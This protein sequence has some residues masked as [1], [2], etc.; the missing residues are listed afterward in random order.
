HLQRII[1]F[2]GL[3]ADFCSAGR[4]TEKPKGV[5][6]LQK[7]C[8]DRYKGL[9]L[10]RKIWQ[11]GLQHFYGIFTYHFVK[12]RLIIHIILFFAFCSII[13]RER[14]MYDPISNSYRMLPQSH[15]ISGNSKCKIKPKIMICQPAITSRD[16]CVLAVFCTT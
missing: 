7:F 2:P 15:S 16:L 14:K 11:G 10:G 3:S 1:L 12:N 8:E 9:P 4:R 6:K 13:C 5:F